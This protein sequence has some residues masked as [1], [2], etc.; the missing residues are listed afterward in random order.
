MDKE[1]FK[2]TDKT[3]KY[4]TEIQQVCQLFFAPEADHANCKQLEKVSKQHGKM[5]LFCLSALMHVPFVC[6]SD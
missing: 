1:M 6:M 5:C 3:A 2:I 4:R